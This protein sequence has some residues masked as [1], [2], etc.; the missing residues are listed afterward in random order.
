MIAISQNADCQN[1]IPGICA[2][3]V[4]TPMILMIYLWQY[5][6]VGTWLLAVSAFCIEVIIK[7]LVILSHLSLPTK[8]IFYPQVWY[9]KRF[10]CIGSVDDNNLSLG[11]LEAGSN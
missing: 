5:F 10:F 11:Q 9:S 2:F 3:L 4:I 6:Y 8:K 7:V 1:L